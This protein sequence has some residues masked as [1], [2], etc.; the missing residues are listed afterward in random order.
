MARIRSIKPEIRTSEKVNSWPIELRYFWILLWGYCDDWGKGRLNYR[1]IKA[2]AFPLDDNIGLD[3]IQLWM[4]HLLAD[5]VIHRY[6][7][8]GNSYFMISNWAEHQR[9]S[10]PAKSVIPDHISCSEETCGNLPQIAENRSPEQRAESREQGAVEQVDDGQPSENL[11]E[12]LF[13]KFWEFYPRRTGKKPA[14]LAFYRAVKRSTVDD[15][16]EGARRFGNDPNLPDEQFIPHPA[17]WLNQDRW[18]DGPLPLRYGKSNNAK[19]ILEATQSLMG[20][21]MKE[22]GY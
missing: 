10:H 17:T 2:D 11:D 7:V 21:E 9:P 18:T 16:L 5:G 14:K 3:Q 4:E 1:L 15:V 22:I 19:K 13:D 20:G 6:E 8:L 12:A